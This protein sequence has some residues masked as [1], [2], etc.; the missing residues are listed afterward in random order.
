MSTRKEIKLIKRE[1]YYLKKQKWNPTICMAVQ[2][3]E[4]EL[5]KLRS[6]DKVDYFVK[7]T[8]GDWIGSLKP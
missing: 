4:S 2:R 3:L 8:N 5:T 6:R 7:L 1:I